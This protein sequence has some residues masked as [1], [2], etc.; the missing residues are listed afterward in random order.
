MKK[1][2]NQL[3]LLVKMMRALSDEDLE[4][5]IINR[6]ILD[7]LYLFKKNRNSNTKLIEAFTFRELLLITDSSS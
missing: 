1:I 7:K 5:A 2:N 6:A 3:L 4:K